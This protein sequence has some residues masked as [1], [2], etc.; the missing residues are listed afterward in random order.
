M[1]VGRKGREPCDDF[2]RRSRLETVQDRGR[3]TEIV[4]SGSHTLPRGERCACAAAPPAPNE[5][6][7][8]RLQR[9]DSAGQARQQ[10]R[11]AKVSRLRDYGARGGYQRKRTNRFE[12]LAVDPAEPPMAERIAG[13]STP[14][15]DCQ[16]VGHVVEI[17]DDECNLVGRRQR[18]PLRL[19][20]KWRQR[21]HELIESGSGGC[22]QL[23]AGQLS[24]PDVVRP[25]LLRTSRTPSWR[26]RRAASRPRAAYSA[27]G[28]GGGALAISA[29]ARSGARS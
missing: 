21:D 6:L 26:E 28:R 9:Q 2:A 4:G 16:G 10:R 8:Q 19:P 18:R 20:E 24:D 3:R 27:R 12:Q 7:Q 29:I 22:R 25:L 14:V 13:L 15:T 5:L 11:S 1:E 23:R 17:R